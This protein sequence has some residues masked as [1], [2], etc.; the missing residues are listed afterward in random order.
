MDAILYSRNQIEEISRAWAEGVEPT[1]P[2]CGILLSPQSVPPHPDV[3]YVRRRVI[4]VCQK[5][6]GNAAVERR[7]A[8]GRR[9]SAPASASVVLGWKEW[10]TVVGP[11]DLGIEAKVDSGARTSALHAEEITLVAGNEGRPEARFVVRHRDPLQGAPEAHEAASELQVPVVDER[12]IRSS[13]GDEEVRPVVLLPLR[14]AG[15]QFTAEVTLTRRD[16][17]QYR[18]LLGRTALRGRFLVDSGRA[19]LGGEPA[20][21]PA[22]PVDAA[23]SAHRA[24]GAS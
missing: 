14:V 1:C 18:M 2:V 21:A 10:V 15:Q 12:L 19:H 17:M 8:G 6:G 20:A 11:P 3:S 7:R 23:E 9:V 5:C 22:S 13:S 4:L 24:G 16:A